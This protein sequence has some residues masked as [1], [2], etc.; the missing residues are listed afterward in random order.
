V[1]AAAIAA[2]KTVDVEG[3]DQ[4]ICDSQTGNKYDKSRKEAQ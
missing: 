1:A 2:T 4:G 3:H